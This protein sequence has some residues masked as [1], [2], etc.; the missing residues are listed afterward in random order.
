MA[1][2]SVS[3]SFLRLGLLEPEL[4]QEATKL[5]TTIANAATIE[6]FFIFLCVFIVFLYYADALHHLDKLYIEHE[7]C[8]RRDGC[9][10][11][12][13]AVSQLVGDE[14]AILGT[15]RHELYALCPTS[16]NAVEGECSRLATLVAAV[17]YCTVDESALV[18]ALY[19]VVGCR[20]LA[21]AL[22]E[23]LIHQS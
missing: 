2:D 9:S 1:Y 10:G 23:H 19:C 6:N 14:E 4:P 22:V 21:A 15:L 18:V 17:E 5:A 11:T 3:T 7:S 16:D 12:A 13:L 20:L 8:K